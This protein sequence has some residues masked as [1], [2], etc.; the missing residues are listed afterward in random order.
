MLAV[1]PT[2]CAA[3]HQ[4]AYTAHSA[5]TSA[6]TWP[7]GAGQFALTVAPAASVAAAAEARLARQA[8]THDAAATFG[9]ASGRV[10]RGAGRAARAAQR[11]AHVARR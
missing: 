10:F 7:G 6:A 3:T 5:I 4:G 8:A 11:G 2:R 1:V 9:P